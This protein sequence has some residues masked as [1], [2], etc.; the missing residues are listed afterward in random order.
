MKDS[1]ESGRLSLVYEDGSTYA[2]NMLVQ[3][4]KFDIV[5][6]DSIHYKFDDNGG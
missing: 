1:I 3:D 2:K 6:I 5:I 4:V